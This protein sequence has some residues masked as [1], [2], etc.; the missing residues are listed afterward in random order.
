ME[1]NMENN[2]RVDEFYQ[3]PDYV[4]EGWSPEKQALFWGL[5]TAETVTLFAP[6][7]LTALAQ[8]KANTFF[9]ERQWLGELSYKLLNRGNQ[10][11]E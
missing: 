6:R 10:H 9:S 8:G 7:F 5:L 4:V 3:A 11:Y 2:T 1:N